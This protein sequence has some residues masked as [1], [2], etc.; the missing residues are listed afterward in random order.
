[1]RQEE[2]MEGGWSRC[3]RRTCRSRAVRSRRVRSSSCA[4]LRIA[5]VVA[6]TGGLVRCANVR[7]DVEVLNG[8]SR[9]DGPRR[10]GG[11]SVPM[12]RVP[13]SSSASR[14]RASAYSPDSFS[15]HH[16]HLFESPHGCTELRREG[17]IRSAT[18]TPPSGATPATIAPLLSAKRARLTGVGW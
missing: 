8:P 6:E 13:A 1:M 7:S 11:L 15:P 12:N 4:A 18:S 5:L 9:R 3:D 10:R 17:C 14:P 2:E 16:P